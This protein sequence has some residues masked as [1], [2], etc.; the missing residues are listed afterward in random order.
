MLK[1]IISRK[2]RTTFLRSMLN[3]STRIVFELMKKNLQGEIWEL[4]NMMA[5]KNEVNLN[6]VFRNIKKCQLKFII[7]NYVVANYNLYI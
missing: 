4:N 2:K 1:L 5:I 7:N 6:C 3:L